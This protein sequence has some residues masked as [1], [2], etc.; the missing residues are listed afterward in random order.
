MPV[1][2]PSKRLG[3]SIQLSFVTKMLKGHTRA[4]P[5][6]DLNITPMVDMLV[7]LVIF[8]L[9]TFSATGEILFITKDIVLPSAFNAT[10]MERAPVIAISNTAVAF[11]GELVVATSSVNPTTF[12]GGKIPVLKDLLDRSR[13]AWVD[14]HPSREF[15]G[16]V[17]I[18]AHNEVPFSVLKMIMKTCAEAQFMGMNFAIQQLA[19]TAPESKG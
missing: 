17:I 12:P 2:A 16:Q 3:N 11:E 10:P 18:Q 9:M 19:H 5:H 8:L 15:N 13:Q 14:V 6:S 7:M 1:K 4:N